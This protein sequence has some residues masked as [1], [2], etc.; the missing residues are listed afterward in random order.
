MAGD[1]LGIGEFSGLTGVT[2]STL[3]HY[4]QLGL[5]V[6]GEV[7][8][9]TGYRRYRP[10][11]AETARAIRTL[12]SLE[13]PLE[14]IGRL[15]RADAAEARTIWTA[16]RERL[17]RRAE[18]FQRGVALIDGALRGRTVPSLE[19]IAQLLSE[20][21]SNE[22]DETMI[23]TTTCRLMGVTLC[24]PDVE[25]AA[26]FYREVLGIAFEAEQHPDGPRHLHA[27]GGTWKPRE[28]FLFT[29]WPGSGQRA[30][31]DFT[32]TDVDATWRRALEAGATSILEP[33]DSGEY[34][35]HAAFSDPFGNHVGVYAA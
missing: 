28:F 13:M 17:R 34:P 24:V 1:L 33:Y 2:I 32:V 25:A 19:T 4:H 18:R 10:D 23:E 29:L 27:C 5:L 21:L 9:W 3:R 22:E 26:R 30:N 14:D 15:L 7:D 20:Q 16:H 8:T 31:V 11:Q 35:R 6:P 12:R